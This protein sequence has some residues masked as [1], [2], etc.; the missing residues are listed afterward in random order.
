M[1]NYRNYPFPRWLIVAI[2]CLS[3]ADP[4]P[5]MECRVRRRG[6][7][8]GGKNRLS[9]ANVRALVE[10]RHDDPFAVL[11]PH[12]VAKGDGNPRPGSRCGA[13]GG[14]RG[15]Q[16]RG[17]GRARP[18]P[19][20]GAV[21]GRARRPASVV[22]LYPARAQCRRDLGGSRPVPLSAGARRDGRLSDPRGNASPPMGAAGR[23]CDRACGCNGRAF[24]GL[25]AECG[26]RVGGGRL[27][28]LG[29]PP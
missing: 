17:R 19:R 5:D 27:Q 22:R 16:R 15:G 23:P 2:G 9:E 26:P 3:G 14:D 8:S 6:M 25:G 11:G 13:P 20:S 18:P 10:A 28:W 12:E 7:A 21:R 4:V 29:R 24:R 1:V